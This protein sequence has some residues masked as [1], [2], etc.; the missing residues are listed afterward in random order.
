MHFN[1]KQEGHDWLM[2]GPGQEGL[3]EQNN[4][5]DEGG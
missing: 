5:M 4:Q 2:K 3:D 1:S